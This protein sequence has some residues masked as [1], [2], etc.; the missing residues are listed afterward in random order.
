MTKKQNE[1]LEEINVA[2]KIRAGHSNVD[3]VITSQKVGTKEVIGFHFEPIGKYRRGDNIS[4][5][6]T[7]VVR[8]EAII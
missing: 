7:D 4:L 5:T 3:C 2:M 1:I 6:S 8:A